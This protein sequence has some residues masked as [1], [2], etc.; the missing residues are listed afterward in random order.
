MGL[1]D[2]VKGALG[3]V[4]TDDMDE[5]RNI[6]ASKVASDGL[7]GAIPITNPKKL[8]EMAE[9][10]G[11]KPEHV[12]AGLTVAKSKAEISP[13]QVGSEYCR[14]IANYTGTKGDGT[15]TAENIDDNEQTSTYACKL[16]PY[17]E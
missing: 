12:I 6:R 7:K 1:V 16:T 10:A 9:Q 14:R 11:Y 2:Y 5:K 17:G 3:I 15:V 13:A 8:K 4:S